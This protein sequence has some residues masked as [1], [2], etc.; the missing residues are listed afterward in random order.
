M[1]LHVRYSLI[2]LALVFTSMTCLA[3]V[4]FLYY[5]SS[6]ENTYDTASKVMSSAL[7]KQMELK[8]KAIANTLSE[9]LTNPF[10][11]Y[12]METIYELLKGI[13]QNE[14]VAHVC[15]FNNDGIVVHDGTKKLSS[16]NKKLEN[17][18]VAET[19]D[20]KKTVLKFTTNHMD[21]AAP[22][23]FGEHQLGGLLISF[24]L[25]TISDDVGKA[26][27]SLSDIGLMGEKKIIWGTVFVTLFFSLI[28]LV[29]AYLVAGAFAR[30]INLLSKLTARIG[31]G[32]YDLDIPIKSTDEIGNLTQAFLRMAEDLK[33]TT[34]SISNY[35]KEIEER[36]RVEEE[37]RESEG[38]FVNFTDHMPA[39]AFMKSEDGRYIFANK[40]YKKIL[41][42][43]PED[44]IGKTD[45]E[46][47]PAEIAAVLQENDRQVLL[48]S[49]TI[50]VVENVEDAEGR[51]RIQLTYKFP[52]FREGKPTILG[53]VALDITDY[54]RTEENLKES[55]ERYYRILEASPDPIVLYDML[56][57]VIY[58]NP[59]FTVVFGW[60]LEELSGRKV[61]FVPDEA[62]PETLKR[63]EM[64]KRGQNFHGFETRRYTKDG[65]SLDIN[66]SA[67]VWRDS[68]GVPAGSVIILRDVTEQK[69]TEAQLR[70]AQKMEAIGTLAG[71]VA[72]DFNNLLQAISGYTQIMLS[73]QMRDK[74]DC[75]KLNEIQKACESAERLIR[76][77]LTFSRKMDSRLRPVDINQEIR[78]V[79]KLLERTIP[80]MIDIKINLS[81]DLKTVSADAIQIEQ[82]LMNLGVN[83][84]D[85][86]PDGGSL[87]IETQNV[88]LD[89]DY[90]RLHLGINPG[91]YVLIAVSDTGHGMEKEM[92][93]HIF[94]PFFTT[95][96]TGKGTGLGLAM[97]YGIIENH[98]G[99]ITCYSEIGL[100]TSFKIYL[101][102]IEQQAEII[103]PDS[104]SA[105]L[106]GGDE[107]ILVVDDEEFIRDI[108]FE[109]LNGHGYGVYSA[110]SGEEALDYYNR[111]GKEVDL[112]ILD[113]GMPGMGGHRCLEELLRLDPS[114]KIII[115][116]GYS[117]NS[118]IN[119]TLES[120][121][122]G[123]VGKPFQMEDLLKTV[124]R[125]LDEEK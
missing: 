10:Y 74:A 115:A 51:K 111:H 41:G 62:L 106:T 101:P 78:Q 100:G 120:G 49:K 122:A 124:R 57:Q 93:E 11:H 72:H 42:V 86:M 116:S 66:M 113:L 105:S 32:E 91:E 121:A 67:A 26:S 60:T 16:Y 83:A 38:R 118:Q 40:A 71:G 95:K 123:F 94:E 20:K 90:C 76:Q 99:Y 1:R 109:M 19:L 35:N 13:K 84:R 6:M 98:K 114:A 73:D 4:L 18:I 117:Y 108:A 79:I 17:E 29:L 107:T 75:R 39:L 33:R 28:G 37:L 87:I 70:Q 46:L 2:M 65:K 36:R 55:E 7:Y 54:V 47:W 77:L 23:K 97:V 82:I 89:E 61:D 68:R 69:K 48:Q 102:A 22:I 119:K 110:S 21:I 88:V 104:I 58:I 81:D 63:I 80:R 3:G 103:S 56:G 15:I 8:G 59:A 9:H 27:R 12:D 45:Q 30:P 25:K 50:E 31:R 85:S 14:D 24:S 52:I 34:T 44:R 125:V 5:R 96:E 92:I 53:G 64:V 43:E 112:V